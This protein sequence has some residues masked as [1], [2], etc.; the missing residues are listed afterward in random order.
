MGLPTDGHTGRPTDWRGAG[1]ELGREHACS[2]ACERGLGVYVLELMAWAGLG[3][4]GRSNVCE[5][6]P[7]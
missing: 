3:S 6:E 7:Q 1:L 4:V 5:L 2:S